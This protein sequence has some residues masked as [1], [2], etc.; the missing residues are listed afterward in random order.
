MIAIL[1]PAKTLNF[2]RRYEH[3]EHSQPIFRAQAV[4][5]MEILR[6][7]SPIDMAGLMKINDELAERNFFRHIEWKEDHTIENSKQSILAYHGAVY[8]GLNA[9]TF[10]EKQLLYA[11]QHLRILSGLYGVLR[12]LDI[13]QPYRLEMATKL[14]NSRGKD[15]YT[16]WKEDITS[17]FNEEFDKEPDRVLINLASNEYFSAIDG[18]KLNAQVI[19]P[20][21]K[22]YRQGVYKN[23]TIYAKRAR[24]LMAR[25]IVENEIDNVEGLRAFE[26]EGY[27]FNV[28]LSNEKELVF[29]R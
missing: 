26:E 22:E 3:V 4:E 23:I 21:F 28:S 7:Y 27:E 10:N 19:T 29:T 24:G 14:R 12:P 8:Q 17:H 25:Y 11:Q 15:L 2:D 20:V 13:V 1:S 16:F 9:E 6:E 18:R 5:I